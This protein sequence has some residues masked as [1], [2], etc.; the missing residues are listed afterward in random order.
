MSISNVVGTFSLNDVV[1]QGGTTGIITETDGATY[2]I[3]YVATG[4]FPNGTG[5]ITNTTS[6]GTADNNGWGQYGSSI[7]NGN[8]TGLTSVYNQGSYLNID[9]SGSATASSYLAQGLAP[10]QFHPQMYIL[11][12]GPNTSFDPN[13]GATIVTNDLGGTAIPLWSNGAGEVVIANLVGT[14]LG[15]TQIWNDIN[16]TPVTITDRSQNII[17]TLTKTVTNR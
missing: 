4:V 6:G 9:L 1:T 14:W 11:Y 8:A 16:P 10:I 5:T 17:H 2:F 7:V 15:A 12:E 13:S 3:A